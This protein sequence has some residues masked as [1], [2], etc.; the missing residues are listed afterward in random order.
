M[1]HCETCLFSPLA[2]LSS[3][4]QCPGAQAPHLAGLS[5]QREYLYAGEFGL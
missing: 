5:L 3:L 4:A 1:G 2:R